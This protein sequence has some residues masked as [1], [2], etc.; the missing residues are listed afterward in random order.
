MRLHSGSARA[1]LSSLCG[2]EGA[3]SH[4]AELKRA[5][6]CTFAALWRT[7][8][9]H[10]TAVEA[11][12]ARMFAGLGDP[13]RVPPARAWKAALT[14]V[15]TAA[16]GYQGRFLA[17]Q[18]GRDSFRCFRYFDVFRSDFSCRSLRVSSAWKLFR[19]SPAP[20]VPLAGGV[21]PDGL[22]VISGLMLS[23]ISKEQHRDLVDKAFEAA[24]CQGMAGRERDASASPAAGPRMLMSHSGRI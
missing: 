8:S 14:G 17:L 16:G 20:R 4:F 1:A 11:C 5:A 23:E 13:A 18:D 2:H 10:T 22:S 15:A 3:G 7:A 21:G 24:P 6:P 9:S 12:V 19:L